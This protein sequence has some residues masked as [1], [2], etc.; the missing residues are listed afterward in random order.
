M[1][2]KVTPAAKEERAKVEGAEKE[3]GAAE[4]A[5]ASVSIHGRFDQNW[6]SFRRTEPV[7]MA[8]IVVK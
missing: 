1:A 3:G 4:E 5:G 7:L 2:S 6:A 8:P